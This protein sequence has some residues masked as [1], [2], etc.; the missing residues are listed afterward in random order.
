MHYNVPTNHLLTT[1]AWNNTLTNLYHIGKRWQH[2]LSCVTLG[3][4]SLFHVYDIIFLKITIKTSFL[5]KSCI[6]FSDFIIKLM[7]MS[8]FHFS[9][10]GPY[11][12]VSVLGK[13]V[14]NKNRAGWWHQ[15]IAIKLIENDVIPL[16]DFVTDFKKTDFGPYQVLY[17]LST[18][19][20]EEI[21]LYKAV[22]SD[23]G[24]K[25][26]RGEQKTAALCSWFTWAWSGTTLN[27]Y[28]CVI[29]YCTLAFSAPRSSQL[30]V[31]CM[32]S[33]IHASTSQRPCR[34]C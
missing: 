3:H 4:A 15:Q 33:F 32:K 17:P 8:I 14:K 5:Y 34:I 24:G 19:R 26:E 28:P 9:R 25:G 18:L 22:W 2:I 29:T 16:C 10:A 23:W 6:S 13:W 31:Q 1:V 30:Y 12:S 20:R 7:N 21:K 11:A 27:T